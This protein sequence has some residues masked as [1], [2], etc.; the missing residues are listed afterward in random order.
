MPQRPAPLSAGNVKSNHERDPPTHRL[1]ES[2]TS[3]CSSLPFIVTTARGKPDLAD[4]KKIRSH[5]MRGKNR[6]VRG[7]KELRV[8]SWFS[9][10]Q[11]YGDLELLSLKSQS[12]GFSTR[13]G[14]GEGMANGVAATSFLSL[15]PEPSR[16]GSGLSF[17]R[18][19]S[20]ANPHMLEHIFNCK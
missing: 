16:A 8:G 12:A 3:S 20:E 17:F 7:P 13:A 14:A 4:R 5:V 11:E 6:R 15:T 18:F 9:T 2:K 19:A 1:M 10:C